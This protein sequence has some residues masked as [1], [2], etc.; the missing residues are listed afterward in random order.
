MTKL[1]AFFARREFAETLSTFGG[2]D[3]ATAVKLVEFY[4]KKKFAKL[5]S[6]IGRISVKHGGYLNRDA[7]GRA[8]ILM[9]GGTL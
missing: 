3:Q 8:V 1:D 6:Q 5:D 7:I 2:L 4:L 9:N